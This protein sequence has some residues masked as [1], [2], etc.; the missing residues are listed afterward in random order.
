MYDPSIGRFTS[1][2]P[3][4]FAAGDANLYRLEGNNPTN[5][6][7]PT[8]LQPGI[9]FTPGMPFTPGTPAPIPR[10][11][12]P[13]TPDNGIGGRDPQHGGITPPPTAHTPGPTQITLPTSTDGSE[14]FSIQVEGGKVI[15]ADL[16]SLEFSANCP[17]G[18]SAAVGT[19]RL[20]KSDKDI[21]QG[22]FNENDHKMDWPLLPP[23]VAADGN[24]R[25]SYKKGIY[26]LQLKGQRIYPDNGQPYYITVSGTI[27]FQ[28]DKASIAPGIKEP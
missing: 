18:M 9:P 10:L 21:V 20:L 27:T 24:K 14:G 6:T 23:N 19:A 11:P 17:L 16:G 12:Y 25:E 4:G 22:Y 15:S 5:E 26:K 1:V 7:D 28:C 3:T 13:I 8:G 2:D